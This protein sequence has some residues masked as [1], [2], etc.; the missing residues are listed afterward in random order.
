VQGQVKW[1][2]NWRGYGFIGRAN[3]RD[4]FVHYTAIVGDGY[5]TLHEGDQV[6]FEIVQGLKG[7][8]ASDVVKMDSY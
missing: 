4:V 6:T 8:Q 1:F 3:G 7:L 2:N 5:R